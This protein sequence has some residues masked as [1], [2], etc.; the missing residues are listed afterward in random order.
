[1]KHRWLGIVGTVLLAGT[2]FPAL[3]A[4][5]TE[6]GPYARIAVLRPHDGETVDFRS[7][8]HP[9][10]RVASAGQGQV[11]LVRLDHLGR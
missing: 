9:T 5:E 3:L 1:M 2:V 11:D 10:S 4:A 7:R 8:L 6:R